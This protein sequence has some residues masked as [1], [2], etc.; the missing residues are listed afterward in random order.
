MLGLIPVLLIILIGIVAL[1][2][3]VRAL[4][5]THGYGTWAALGTIFLPGL[6][7]GCIA[8]ML[9]LGLGLLTGLPSI[10]P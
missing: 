10:N 4:K 1:I 3:V 6:F 8:M 5:S 7:F 2:M 9:A